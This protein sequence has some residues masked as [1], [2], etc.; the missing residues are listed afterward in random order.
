MPVENRTVDGRHYA[1]AVRQHHAALP[2]IRRESPVER[3]RRQRVR[4]LH[5][6][7]LLSAVAL[8]TALSPL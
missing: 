6:V 2:L 5:F 8:V 1:R 7:I 3:R 4:L